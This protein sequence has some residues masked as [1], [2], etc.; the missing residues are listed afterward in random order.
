MAAK[1]RDFDNLPVNFK[2]ETDGS[3]LVPFYK[4]QP[5]DVAA[6]SGLTDAQLR[7]SALPVSSPAT[8][9][10]LNIDG[11][12]ASTANPIPTSINGLVLNSEYFEDDAHSSG[13]VGQFV[14][15]VRNDTDTALGGNGDFS[16]FQTDS[17]GR[18][19]VGSRINA[20]DYPLS[21]G[22]SSSAAI[23]AGLS[24]TGAIESAQDQPSI[25]ILMRSNQPI[26]LTVRQFVDIAGT[27]QVP[28]IVF[29][30][31]ANQ[32]FARSLTINGNFLRVIATNTGTSATT[33]FELNVAYG[34]L[35][36]ADSTGTMPVSEPPLV[37]TGEP[38]RIATVNNILTPP[39]S[40]NALNVSGYRSASVQVI[41]TGTISSGQFIFEQSNDNVNWVA[42]PVFNAALV[43]AVPITGVVS[44]AATSVIYN[45]AIRCNFLRLRISTA[46]GGGGSIQSFSRFS[47]DSW[48][49]SVNLVASNT[50]ANNLAQV[51]GTVTANLGTF[52]NPTNANILNS[53]ATTNGT[54]IKASAG[55]VY[56]ITASNNGAATAFVKLYNSTT[57]TVGTTAI[58]VIIPVP[59]GGVINVPFGALGSRFSTGIC[60]SITNL[61]ADADTT[62]VAAG[63]V[64]VVTSF[65]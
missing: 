20:Y 43:T 6:L 49:P 64:K 9:F 46:I 5:A 27:I 55:N 42:L 21:T 56:N 61:I 19:K 45:F 4:M 29:Y 38:A 15:S 65:I 63:Q 41:G 14:L 53:A 1:G 59:A 32:G 22:N 25:S 62:A 17:L 8:G 47:T 34:T 3:D 52:T 2:T 37:I 7:A 31:A 54:V 24:F 26:T 12:A 36:D 28:D 51:S 50:A 33:N 57:V 11:V 16:P 30:V 13:D 35:G 39:A 40:A 44:A 58:A 23:G 48:T 10:F 18:L 60:L